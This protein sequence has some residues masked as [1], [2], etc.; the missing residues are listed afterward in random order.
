[1]R[2][3][4][5]LWA[6]LIKAEGDPAALPSS[7]SPCFLLLRAVIPP[8]PPPRTS[9]SSAWD[10]LRNESKKKKVRKDGTGADPTAP[11][12]AARGA[13]LR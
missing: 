6:A 2:Y 11:R 9:I 10:L 13:P 5:L 4:A 8:F 3:S 7:S 12:T 1:M